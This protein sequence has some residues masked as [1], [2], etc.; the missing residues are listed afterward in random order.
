MKKRS[1]KERS[2]D[3]LRVSVL[4][5][6]STGDDEDITDHP[7]QQEKDITF[8]KKTTGAITT[9]NNL[10]EFQRQSVLIPKKREHT[11]GNKPAIK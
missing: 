3:N 6:M 8:F 2:K 5:E 4:H 11:Q 9:Q 1:A 7:I 10:C